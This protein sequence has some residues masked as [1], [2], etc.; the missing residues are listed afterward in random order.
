MVNTA[1]ILVC[2]TA[3]YS[4][5][6]EETRLWVFFPQRLVFMLLHNLTFI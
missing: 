1:K 5:A 2:I 3:I 4:N 6:K